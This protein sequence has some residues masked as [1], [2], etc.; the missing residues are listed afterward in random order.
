MCVNEE[1]PEPFIWF[2]T[3]QCSCFGRESISYTN[4]LAGKLRLNPGLGN[5][6]LTPSVGSHGGFIGIASHGLIAHA[7]LHPT[8][9][10]DAVVNEKKQGHPPG[11]QLHN[12]AVLVENQSLTHS[13]QTN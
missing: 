3:P 9:I 6:A 12:A 13:T 8:S 5:Q 11:F 4:K 10:H 7:N 1:K 2:S